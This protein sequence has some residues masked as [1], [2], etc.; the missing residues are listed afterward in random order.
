MRGDRGWR[1]IEDEAIAGCTLEGSKS[2]R[3]KV[4][5]LRVIPVF[6][7]EKLMCFV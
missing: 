4:A 1:T 5:D 6:L 2:P 3:N 7:S